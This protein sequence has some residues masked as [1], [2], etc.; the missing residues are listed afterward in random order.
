MES[1]KC[2][3][4]CWKGPEKRNNP[5]LATTTVKHPDWRGQI[6]RWMQ[7]MHMR[8][9]LHE[10][11]SI[12]II[13]EKNS[14]R[15]ERRRAIRS[16]PQK[17][18]FVMESWRT[19]ASIHPSFL[20]KQNTTFSQYERERVDAMATFYKEERYLR[21]K[22]PFPAKIITRKLQRDSF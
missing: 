3:D 17:C 21:I 7:P 2:R 9:V 4:A 1:L 14:P 5:D 13:K 8:L 18:G 16:W 6:S 12:I 11:S 19:E 15:L 22:T 10:L 20:E